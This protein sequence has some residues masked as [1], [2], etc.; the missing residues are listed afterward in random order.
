MRTPTSGHL[1]C[2]RRGL[3]MS[4]SPPISSLLPQ[5]WSLS[6]PPC[7]SSP[8]PTA[9]P[10]LPPRKSIS[11]VLIDVVH[12]LFYIFFKGLCPYYSRAVLLALYVHK[13]TDSLTVTRSAGPKNCSFA[14]HPKLTRL[15]LLLA[16]LK[17]SSSFFVFR[18]LI[19]SSC[20]NASHGILI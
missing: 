3:L 2:R 14:F 9:S 15:P 12:F 13:L 7:P 4:F 19:W 10:S 1:G 11:S 6:S 18:I 20:Q 16:L 8:L 5:P 17:W